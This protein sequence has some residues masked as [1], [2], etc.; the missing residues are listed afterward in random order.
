MRMHDLRACKSGYEITA[1]KPGRGPLAALLLD[2]LT[3]NIGR[4]E[5][6]SFTSGAMEI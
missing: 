5:P 2:V 4:S 1:F 3:Q 6:A